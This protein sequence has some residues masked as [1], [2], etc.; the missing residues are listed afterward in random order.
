MMRWNSIDYL[1]VFGIVFLAIFS[2]NAFGYVP[3]VQVAE[4]ID[5]TDERIIELENIIEIKNE[6]IEKLELLQPPDYTSAIILVAWIFFIV[7]CIFGWQWFDKKKT[8]KKM[9]FDALKEK[10]R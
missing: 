7:V 6:R 5:I 10:D 2:A 1:M 3:S 4:V 9:E 8:M